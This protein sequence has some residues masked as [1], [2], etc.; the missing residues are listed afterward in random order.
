MDRGGLIHI[1]DT[2]FSLFSSMEMEIRSHLRAD[3]P[4]LFTKL[5]QTIVSSVLQNEEVQFHWSILSA[6]WISEEADELL[7]MIVEHWTTVR[8]F[9]FVASFMENFK[10][11][12]KTTTQ[13][14]KGTRKTLIGRTIYSFIVYLS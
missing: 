11:E 12:N 9:S 10:R 1:S 5:K 14:S 4:S 6:N 8:G 3:N 7:K 2:M 13:K